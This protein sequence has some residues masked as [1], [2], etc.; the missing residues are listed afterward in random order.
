MR[1]CF[2]INHCVKSVQTDFSGPYFPVFSPNAAKYGPERTPHLDI[3]RAA[4]I[5][6]NHLIL[7]LGISF[8]YGAPARDILTCTTMFNNFLNISF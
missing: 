7:L 2:D 5:G 1:L 6:G 8:R 3:F 4:N